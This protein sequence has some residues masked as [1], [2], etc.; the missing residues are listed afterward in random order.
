ML[1]PTA[2]LERKAHPVNSPIIEFDDDWI[3]INGV[4][5][6]REPLFTEVASIL[7]TP[8]A[9]L[10][11]ENGEVTTNCY[12]WSHLGI[13]ASTPIIDSNNPEDITRSQRISILRLL[14]EPDEDL[15][16][17]RWQSNQ[18]VCANSGCSIE[19]L[20]AFSG[21]L[22][23]C[24]F[25]FMKGMALNQ[26][27]SVKSGRGLDVGLGFW[28]WITHRPGEMGAIS[29]STV[30]GLSLEPWD[31]GIIGTIDLFFERWT[32]PCEAL[33]KFPRALG[34][35]IITTVST[36]RHDG[37]YFDAMLTSDRLIIIGSL[38]PTACEWKLV[39]SP[40]ITHD[41]SGGV[42]R[43]SDLLTLW[44]CIIFVSIAPVFLL[45]LGS[46]YFWPSVLSKT[47]LSL[48]VLWAIANLVAHSGGRILGGTSPNKVRI[49]ASGR[50]DTIIWFYRGFRRDSMT[51]IN[52]L[53]Q[54]LQ[55]E[56]SCLLPNGL[57]D[58]VVSEKRIS[59]PNSL[60]A[61]SI[62]AR[63]NAQVPSQPSW[64]QSFWQGFWR[65]WGRSFAEALPKL[66]FFALILLVII[67]V[68]IFALG[69]PH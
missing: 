16:I 5:F 69:T 4:Q 36:E 38:L 11:L 1:L 62:D 59:H 29:A 68:A 56:V 21:T 13:S 48:A 22:K 12:C 6:S 44:F 64:Q 50:D 46:Y 20:K 30:R 47:C 3:K 32:Q 17:V 57:T 2:N 27:R 9:M 61:K 40:T 66:I 41:F 33:L 55:H 52:S 24:G 34:E 35:R 23:I 25:P 49:H 60:Q 26:L 42:P 54:R 14:I 18:I 19:E 67:A 28:K 65:Y 39:T 43:V 10:S 51:E 45:L 63:R 37:L 15:A 53:I 31:D 8:D 58:Q 7:G